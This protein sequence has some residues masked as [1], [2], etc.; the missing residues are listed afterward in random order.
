M[1]TYYTTTLVLAIGWV[2]MANAQGNQ[3]RRKVDFFVCGGMV[4]LIVHHNLGPYFGKSFP[5]P[6]LFVHLSCPL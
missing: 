1:S 2:A 5:K 6:R 3:I 4:A